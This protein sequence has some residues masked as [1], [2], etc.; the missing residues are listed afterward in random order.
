MSFTF[1]G[2]K[3]S[4]IVVAGQQI[5]T[6]VASAALMPFSIGGV[7]LMWLSFIT[8]VVAVKAISVNMVSSKRSFHAQ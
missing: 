3:F 5:L 2:S 1:L 7:L 4:V 8:S 6:V